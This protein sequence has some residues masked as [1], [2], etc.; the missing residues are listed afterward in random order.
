MLGRVDLLRLGERPMVQPED[1][2]S[3]VSV[4]LKIRARDGDWFVGIVRED[5]QGTSGIEAEAFYRAGIDLGL[6]QHFLDTIGDGIPYI[7]S[8]LFLYPSC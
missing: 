8:G 2:V 6:G 3:V 1:D 7:C 5:G 4:I